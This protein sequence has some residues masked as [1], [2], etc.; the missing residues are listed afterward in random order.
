MCKYSGALEPRAVED[1]LTAAGPFVSD[2]MTLAQFRSIL[3][4]L[5]EVID[6]SKISDMDDE[7]DDDNDYED[8]DDKNGN[9]DNGDDNDWEDRY[10]SEVFEELLSKVS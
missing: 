4:A 7:D 1:A 9:N 10:T 6:E 5:E 3:A 8:D 2:V